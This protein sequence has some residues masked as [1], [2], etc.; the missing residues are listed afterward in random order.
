[1]GISTISIAQC[2][3][4]VRTAHARPAVRRSYRPDMAEVATLAVRFASHTDLG[5]D[6]NVPFKKADIEV[7]PASQTINFK[8]DV[9]RWFGK[10]DF[11]NMKTQL[12]PLSRLFRL[13]F[14]PPRFAA[15][16]RDVIRK[17]ARYL[18]SVSAHLCPY[19]QGSAVER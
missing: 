16:L 6:A 11:R 13:L 19:C 17:E 1:M 7:V 15:G 10:L 18:A 3:L 5:T 14:I 2:R 4:T 8:A 9:V 12:G